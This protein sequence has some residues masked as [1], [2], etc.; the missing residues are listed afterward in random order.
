MAPKCLKRKRC[1]QE[2]NSFIENL[3]ARFLFEELPSG[4][5]TAVY[6]PLNESTDVLRLKKSFVS[7]IAASLRVSI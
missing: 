1:S 5:V 6:H 2:L 3:P 4:I 7:S